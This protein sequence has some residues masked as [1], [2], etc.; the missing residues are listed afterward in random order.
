MAE[1]SQRNAFKWSYQYQANKYDII[2]L[3]RVEHC[4]AHF[5]LEGMEF[6]TG[7]KIKPDWNRNAVTLSVMFGSL[8]VGHVVLYMISTCIKRDHEQIRYEI[9]PVDDIDVAN[10]KELMQAS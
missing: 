3:E 5:K 1:N 9:E 4:K 6:L 7:D 8:L 2:G 10:L